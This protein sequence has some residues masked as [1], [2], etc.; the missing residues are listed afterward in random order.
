MHAAGIPA[1]GAEVRAMR[2]ALDEAKRGGEAGE[3]PI[4]AVVFGPDG[5]VLARAH[6]E[7]L[8]S[9]DPT[10]HAEIRAIR[11]A[12]GVLGDRF[13]TGCT[14]AVTLEPCIMC[15]GVIREARLARVIFG[16]WEERAGA[17]GSLYD[18]VR[19]ERLAQ[20]PVEVIAGIEADRARTLLEAFF[21]GRREAPGE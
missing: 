20:P 11:E 4:G 7:R 3:I 2:M 16:A 9:T 19:D 14:L 18:I 21:R 1:S 8:H 6:N 10:G 5:E 13:L 17:A 12:C 15:A